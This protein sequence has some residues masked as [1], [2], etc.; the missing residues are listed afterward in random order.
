MSFSAPLSTQQPAPLPPQPQQQQQPMQ[1]VLDAIRQQGWGGAS[2]GGGAA[3]PTVASSRGVER[4]SGAKLA[5]PKIHEGHSAISSRPFSGDG[6]D[7]RFAAIAAI[8][9]TREASEAANNPCDSMQPSADSQQLRGTKGECA[10]AGHANAAAALNNTNGVCEAIIT[11]ARYGG[12]MEPSASVPAVAA[13]A[14]SVNF[15][16]EGDERR[17]LSGPFGSYSTTDE[18]LHKKCNDV[19][20]GSALESA[21]SPTDA[22]GGVLVVSPAYAV[23]PARVSEAP[24]P[25]GAE[26]QQLLADARRAYTAAEERLLGDGLALREDWMGTRDLFFAAGSLF[27]AVGEAADAAR[28]LLH[29]T[30]INRAFQNDSEALVTLAMSVEQL[31][32]SHPRIAV[33]SLLRL[34]PCYAQQDLRYQAARCHRDAAEILENILEAKEEAVVQYRA[35]LDMYAETKVAAAETARRWERQ[36]QQQRTAAVCGDL[37]GTPPLPPSAGASTTNGDLTSPTAPSGVEATSL[38]P[39]QPFVSPKSTALVPSSGGASLTSSVNG[40]KSHSV[41]FP[42]HA[43]PQYRVSTTVQRSLADS[44]R[45]RL[46]VLLTLLGRYDEAREAALDCAANVPR[47]LPKTKYLLYATLCVLARGASVRKDSVSDPA[48]AAEAAQ[49]RETP[50]IPFTASAADT[51]YFDSL[52]DTE[53]F[54]LALQDEDRTFQ[55]GKE[56]ALVRALLAANRACSLTAFDEAVRAYKEYS[57]T[58]PCAAFEL[59]AGECRRSLFEHMERFA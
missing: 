30:F 55:R 12:I 54:F 23:V 25:A 14:A 41:E 58:E 42:A 4:H 56:N 44:C 37:T 2:S 51:V 13:T 28:C 52:Y 50:T 1:S 18:V 19:Q 31:K 59:L 39:E 9:A 36:Q 26:M 40:Q 22:S 20:Q 16:A 35:A 29:A 6:A 33:D 7:K 21:D 15:A 38:G 45:W 3:M 17:R 11:A 48:A 49:A 32:Q 27:A 5:C 57:T 53:K 10:P 34:A 24:S 47:T 46:M 8:A 43:P